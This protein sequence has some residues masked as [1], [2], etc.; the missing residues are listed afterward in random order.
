MALAGAGCSVEAVAPRGHAITTTH[1]LQGFYAYSGFLSSIR[2]AII[3]AQPDFVI[4]CD[5]YATESLHRLHAEAASHGLAPLIERSLGKPE[6]YAAIRTRGSLL[7]E[8]KKL[9]ICVPD[10]ENL[11]DKRALRDWLATHQLPAYIKADGTS[12]GVGVRLVET[13]EQAE[14]AFDALSSPPG[15]LRTIKRTL[16]D[17]DMRL[18]S[19]CLQR[20]RA[21]VSTQKVVEGSEANCAVSCWQGRVLGCISVEVLKRADEY[22]P[23]TVVRL[24]DNR[25]VLAAAEKLARRFQLSGLF[26]LDFILEAATGKAYLLEMNA[27]ATQTCHLQMGPGRNLIEPL[28]D[29]LLG[30]PQQTSSTASARVLDTIALFPAEWKRDSASHFMKSGYHDVPW[31]EPELIRYSLRFRLQDLSW[32]SYRKWRART[33]ALKEADQRRAALIESRRSRALSAQDN[34]T[35][36]PASR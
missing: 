9:G 35:T 21:V 14:H 19:P 27:R 5:D 34:S 11:P 10:T 17:K 8:A 26:G 15:V 36:T 16:V 32:M 24:I 23:A 28:V 22:G 13:P 1:A 29:E 12:G 2:A 4:P 31:E 30:M 7:S 3:A 25:D 33:A 20:S 18:L 6:H